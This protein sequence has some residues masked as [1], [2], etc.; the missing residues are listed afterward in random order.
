MALQKQTKIGSQRKRR[1][2]PR[3]ESMLR[4]S[5]EQGIPPLE[6][7]TPLQARQFV[8]AAARA[9]AGS[10]KPV[11]DIK[12]VNIP[13]P[14]GQIPLRIYSPRGTGPFPVLVYFHGGGWVICNLD[15]HDNICRF[16][17]N[18]ACCLVVSVDY[19]LAPESKFPA[20]VDDAYAATQWV[21]S[22]VA[23]SNGNPA[24]IAVGGDSSGANL[25]AAVALMAKAKGDPAL[26]F[27][28]LINPVTNL[29]SFDTSSY[30]MFADGYG[31]TRES[32]KW[33]AR[34]YLEREED[35][36]NTLASPLLADNLS[37]L[38]PA[39]VVTS[40]CDVL[41]DEGEDYAR[42]LKQAGVSVKCRRLKGMIHLGV[43]WAVA[44]EMLRDVLDEAAADLR[45]AFSKQI[46]AGV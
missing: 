25:A 27:Q 1:L 29:A 8:I 45:R 14:G 9:L 40:E 38:P 13:G 43:L 3:I 37:G 30:S 46:T 7:M 23:A 32:M 18:K 2:D 17:S 42:R 44:S 6:E 5:E 28:L 12:N 16:F 21:A 22:N 15:T 34:Q 36:G 26:S 39:L 33:F 4:Q 35:R 11:A 24:L 10:P 19:R 41:R 20:A 31:L